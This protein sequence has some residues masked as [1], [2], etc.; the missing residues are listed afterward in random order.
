MR[1]AVRR[2]IDANNNLS[3]KQVL[4]AEVP[5]IDFRIA[6]RAGIQVAGVPEAPLRQFAVRGSLRR[7]QPARK[8]AGTVGWMGEGPR[9]AYW[10]AKL[11]LVKYMFAVFANAGPA[12]WKLVATFIP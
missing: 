8:W 6:N 11:S 3:R 5:L 1:A 10:V 9:H 2:V 4:N 7:R 12:Y